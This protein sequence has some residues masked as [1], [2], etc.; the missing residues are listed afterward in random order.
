M[1]SKA[2]SIS[3]RNLLA[4]MAAGGVIA[5][6]AVAVKNPGTIGGSGSLAGGPLG[7]SRPGGLATAERSAWQAAVGSDFTIGHTR[8]RLAGIRPLPR[9]GARPANLRQ[10]P[11]IAEFELPLGQSLP[12]NL[13]YSVRAARSAAF[14][15]FMSEAG[16]AG[17]LLAV[18]N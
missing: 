16:Q 9:H 4:G 8:M 10:S 12:G 11:F 5:A 3:R 6:L 18:F 13:L 1:E 7:A 14:D 17:R 15:I 2:S